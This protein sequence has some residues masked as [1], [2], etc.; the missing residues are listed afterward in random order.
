MKP[1]DQIIPRLK[2]IISENSDKIED[3]FG[4]TFKSTAPL[5]YNSVDLRHSGFKLAPVDTNMFPAGFNNLSPAERKNAVKISAQYLSKYYPDVRKI[6]L[7]TEDHTRNTYYLENIAILSSILKDSGIEVVISNFKTCQEKEASTLKSHSG[8]DVSFV[9]FEKEN[10]II[11]STDGFI[12]D[13]VLVNNDLTDGAPELIQNL[14]QPVIPPVGFGWYQRKKTSHF[15]TYNNLARSFCREFDLDPWLIST[16]FSH[17]GIVNF[18]E[19]KG[20]ECVARKVDKLLHNIQNK[21]NEYDIK[22]EPYVFIKSNRGTYGMGIMTAKSADDVLQMGRDIRK[23]MNTI[24]GGTLNTEVIIQEGVPTIDKVNEH[25]AE[26]MM[27][28]IGGQSVGCI[29]RLNTQRD[30]YNNLNSKGMEFASIKEH[31]NGRPICDTLNLVAR[32]ASY[33]SA[34]ECYEDSYNI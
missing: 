15:D 17:C 8:L 34:W 21:Y 25:P 9:P 11:K 7:I 6:A 23:K 26:P 20:I 27:Y 22:E 16:L 31:D 14:K 32:L 10:D 5:F 13:M 18:K 24:K 3:W 4:N 33:A 29:Y 12:P 19:K 1:E 2:K 28:M 30:S